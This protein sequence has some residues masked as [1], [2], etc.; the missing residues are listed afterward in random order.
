M[1]AEI[2]MILAGECLSGENDL[3]LG[4]DQ[5]LSVVSLDDAVRRR[6][7]HRFVVDDIALDLFAF[8]AAL[9]FPIL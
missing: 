9:R 7:L 2:F 3:M 1:G 4:I 5:C 6:H 8:T